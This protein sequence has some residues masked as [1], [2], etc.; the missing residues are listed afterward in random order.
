MREVVAIFK[1]AFVV[2]INGTPSLPLEIWLIS[3][4]SEVI[5]QRFKL[6]YRLG[7]FGSR[8]FCSQTNRIAHEPSIRKKAYN[9]IENT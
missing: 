6:I 9:Y 2:I 4:P 5:E 7:A 1:N 8:H 3:M